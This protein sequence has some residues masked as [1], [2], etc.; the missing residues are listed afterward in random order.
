MT[1]KTIDATDLRNNLGE[2]ISL[3]SRG[4]RIIIKRRGQPTVAMIDLDVLE[5]LMEASDPEYVA[6]IKKARK[7]YQQ[8]EVFSM[9]EVFGKIRGGTL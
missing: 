9:D 3:V 1:I 5:D 6:S 7:E 4:E 2:A 8:G